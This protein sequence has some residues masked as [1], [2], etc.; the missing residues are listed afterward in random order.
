MPGDK[1]LGLGQV[2]FRLG[3]TL[4]LE[5]GLRL[6]D[7]PT[8]TLGLLQ[9]LLLAQSLLKLGNK[10]LRGACPLLLVGVSN[11]LQNVQGLLPLPLLEG[12]EST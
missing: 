6:I 12:N 2:F 10:L 3:I 9:P 5:A 11:R 8:V 1:D 7:G 4:L